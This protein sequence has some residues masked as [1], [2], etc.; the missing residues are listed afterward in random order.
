MADQS[1]LGVLDAAS[2]STGH[3]NSVVVYPTVLLA[4]DVLTLFEEGDTYP[5]ATFDPE[6]GYRLNVNDYVTVHWQAGFGGGSVYQLSL[7]TVDA[8]YDGTTLSVFSMNT[9][10]DGWEG[11]FVDNGVSAT[12]TFKRSA[13]YSHPQAEV[14]YKAF[15]ANDV[16]HVS[17]QEE[18]YVMCGFTA[19]PQDFKP[20][21]EEIV[22]EDGCPVGCG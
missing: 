5:F 21:Y 19:Y 3:I 7:L 8:D 11:S 10:G 12:L 17:V 6:P 14:T 9:F 1:S 13:G 20:H 2:A 16:P 4:A 18:S 15:S 22:D